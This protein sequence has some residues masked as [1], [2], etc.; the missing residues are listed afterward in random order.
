MSLGRWE[1][2]TGTAWVPVDFRLEIYL[3][4]WTF[5]QPLVWDGSAWHDVPPEEVID[6]VA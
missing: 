3:P 4:P 5:V 2:W 1:L 6:R